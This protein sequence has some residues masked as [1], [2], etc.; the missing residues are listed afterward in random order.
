MSSC[1]LFPID[2]AGDSVIQ[3]AIEGV[4]LAVSFRT[5]RE[6]NSHVTNG[7]SDNFCES[8]SCRSDESCSF[9]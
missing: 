4:D 1:L 2:N 3:Y 5:E 8:I 9:L 7:V 6:I